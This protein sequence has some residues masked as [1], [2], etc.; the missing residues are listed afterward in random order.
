MIAL[1]LGVTF[2]EPIEVIDSSEEG[3]LINV[4]ESISTDFPEEGTLCNCFDIVRTNKSLLGISFGSGV[5]FDGC[6][7]LKLTQCDAGLT[8]ALI[9]LGDSLVSAAAAISASWFKSS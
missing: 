3:I 6:S 9:F 7:F 1:L 8:N 5:R 4:F 2:F